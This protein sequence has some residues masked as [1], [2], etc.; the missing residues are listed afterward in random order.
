[1]CDLIT[2]LAEVTFWSLFS[3][4]VSS[5]AMDHIQRKRKNL[6]IQLRANI[7]VGSKK[8]N[9]EKKTDFGNSNVDNNTPATIT[10][11]QHQ[12]VIADRIYKRRDETII[13]NGLGQVAPARFNR[14][15]ADRNYIKELRGLLRCMKFK[16]YENNENLIMFGFYNR[17]NQNY[18]AKLRSM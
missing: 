11:P 16:C 14:R 2:I 18:Y 6:K 5:E 9:L 10:T 1:M 7:R 8:N 12:Q 13:S 4:V 3:L 17:M 15:D